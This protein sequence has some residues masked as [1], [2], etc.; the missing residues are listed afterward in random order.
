MTNRLAV[1][2]DRGN[3]LGGNIIFSKN[4][5]GRFGE[6]LAEF[7][8]QSAHALDFI[9]AGVAYIRQPD[10]KILRYGV[11]AGRGQMGVALA[12]IENNTVDGIQTRA[13]HQADVQRLIRLPG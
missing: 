13:R 12:T 5:D 3:I 8:V 9:R 4:S 10:A 6:Q 11:F 2:S 1:A 7:A